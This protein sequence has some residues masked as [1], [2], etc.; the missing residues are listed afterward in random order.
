MST[1][2]VAV[3]GTAMTDMSRRDL[4]PD[5]LA[6][7]VVAEALADACVRAEDLAL[8]VVANASGGRLNDQGC[9][10]GQSWLRK[11][12]LGNVPIVNIDNSCAGGSSALYIGA[13]SARAE[14]RPVLVLGVEKMWTGDR[15]AT[16]DAIESGLPS[17]YRADM[18]SRL[19]EHGN[20]AGS[21]LMGLNASW[22]AQLMDERDVTIEQIAAAAVKARRHG[23]LNPLAQCQQPVTMDEVLGSAQ[24]AGV[25]TRLMCSSF[26]D[27]GAALVLAGSA[28]SFAQPVAQI[29]GSVARSGCGSLD[30]HDRLAETSSAAYESFGLGPDDFDIVELHD[31]TSAEE[32]FALESLSFFA[33]GEAGPATMSGDTAIGGP[34]VTVN[35][36]GGLVA[37]GHPLAATGIAQVVEIVSHIRGRAGA[38][39]VQGARLGLAVNTGGIVDGEAGYVGVTAI[40]GP[41]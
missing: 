6:L 41:R 39:Q 32:L 20:P 13:L 28:T 11:S 21:I 3:L 30:Y 2:P 31:A 37:R 18:Y 9:V 1:D 26:T 17:D 14:D 15:T 40:A 27:G 34:G 8:V 16:L 7:Q 5:Q 38:R 24:V 10:R 19:A 22:A 4:N 36:S 29:V 25:L 23:S 35:P 33:P 12:A